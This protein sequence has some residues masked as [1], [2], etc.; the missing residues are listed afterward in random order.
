MYKIYQL[1]IKYCPHNFPFKLFEFIT[2]NAWAW[3]EKVYLWYSNVTHYNINNT[4]VACSV[5]KIF[6]QAKY[7]YRPQWPSLHRHNKMID[8]KNTPSPCEWACILRVDQY[9][10]KLQ[11]EDCL[12]HLDVYCPHTYSMKQSAYQYRCKI[13]N[14]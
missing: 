12:W 7:N 2:F 4:K 3:K 5:H 9:F 10:G 6:K 1:P 14:W 8:K 13:D 11:Q